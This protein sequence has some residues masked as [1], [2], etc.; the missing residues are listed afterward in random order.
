L[1]R[2][3]L[4]HSGRS[5]QIE[6]RKENYAE[7]IREAFGNGYCLSDA[8]WEKLRSGMFYSPWHHRAEITASKVMIFHAK[9]DPNVPPM[10]KVLTHYLREW[11]KHTPY[12]AH[13]LRVSVDE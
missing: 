2:S 13:G 5:E 9:D 3:G 10:G 4:E 11:H 12:H 7:Y 8:N 6:T 1:S